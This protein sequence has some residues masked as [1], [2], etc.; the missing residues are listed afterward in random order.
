MEARLRA[1]RSA[2]AARDYPAAKR[3]FTA[4]LHA[5]PSNSTAQLNLGIIALVEGDAAAGLRHFSAVPGDPRALIGKLDCELRLKRLTEA[6]GTAKQLDGMTAANAAASAHIGGLLA[7]A[8]EYAAALPFLRRAGGAAAANMLGTA[9]E[10]SGNLPAAVKAFAEAVRLEP[11]NEEYR[12]DHAA[13]LLNAGDISGSVAAFRTA[14]SVFPKSA[15]IRMGLGSALYLS[16][17]YEDAV[18]ALL[19][20]VR[21][22]P[23][24]RAFD[25]LGKSYESAGNLQSQIRAEFEKYIATQPADAVAYTHYAAIVGDPVKARKALRRALELD[26]RLA[27]AHLQ[28]GI[29]EQESGNTGA[30]LKALQQ[31]VV[32]EP[33]NAAVHYRLSA[34]YRK[35]GQPEK[36]AAALRE[37]RRLRQHAAPPAY[38]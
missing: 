34:V 19:E 5:D 2:L 11:A 25:L 17:A 18:L 8:G 32:L 38:E 31:A 26:A 4:V 10:K 23:A 16:G 27:A 1:G 14:A 15:R 21:L 20:A 37:F 6:H 7:T 36:A 24:S 33:G 3:E 35:L 22:Q 29:L 12:I 30:A 13:S 9:E 28:L